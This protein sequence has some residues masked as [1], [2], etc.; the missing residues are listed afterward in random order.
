MKT[1]LISAIAFG[2]WLFLGCEKHD[3]AQ[4]ADAAN[5]PNASTKDESVNEFGGFRGMAQEDQ[6]I[7]LAVLDR[8]FLRWQTYGPEMQVP[9]VYYIVIKDKDAPDD[10]LAMLRK[11]GRDVF[12]GSQ[13]RHNIGVQLS[14]DEIER[15]DGKVVVR[16]G[17]LFGKLGG[18]W[19][20][21]IL[22]HKNGHWTVLSWEPDILSCQNAP[23]KAWLDNRRLTLDL[24]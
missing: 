8:M 16:G 7:Y 13:Y 19:G 22:S 21:F 6:E 18:E 2:T 17:Y 20:P 14:L 23:N 24:S 5:L 10:L 3:Q 11:S 9:L 4:R 12:P 15:T 1:P